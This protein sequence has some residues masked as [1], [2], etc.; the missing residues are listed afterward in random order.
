MTPVRCTCA[1]LTSG[2]VRRT[3]ASHWCVALVRRTGAQGPQS[4]VTGAQGPSRPTVGIHPN[5]CGG[6]VRLKNIGRRDSDHSLIRAQARLPEKGSG[7]LYR[8]SF[9]VPPLRLARRLQP[10]RAHP[11]AARA[12][13]PE[14]VWPG[15][16]SG[17]RPPRGHVAWRE[18]AV[19]GAGGAG[20]Q[21]QGRHDGRACQDSGRVGLRHSQ[22]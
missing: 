6:N 17:G 4:A 21:G 18:P 15:E 9:D 20:C 19:A 22:A 10:L 7:P 8:R 5:P 11:C 14:G 13:S 1:R 3:G 16:S 2:V 12:R